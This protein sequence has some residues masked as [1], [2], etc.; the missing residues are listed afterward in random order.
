MIKHCSPAAVSVP[1]SQLILF[2]LLVDTVKK[3]KRSEHQEKK[4]IM[5]RKNSAE[6][7]RFGLVGCGAIGQEHIRNLAFFS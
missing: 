2:Y 5:K 7:L 4:I 6:Q 1:K 3:I